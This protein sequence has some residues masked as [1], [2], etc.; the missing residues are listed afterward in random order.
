MLLQFTCSRT[1]DLPSILCAAVVVVSFSRVP[2]SVSLFA[3]FFVAISLSVV[4]QPNVEYSWIEVRRIPS[5]V[6]SLPVPTAERCHIFPPAGHSPL[7][8]S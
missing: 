3:R 6:S 7:K 1:S 8:L 5:V 4:R 2:S